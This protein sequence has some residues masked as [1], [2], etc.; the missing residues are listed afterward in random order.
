MEKEKLEKLLN[1]FVKD[2]VFLMQYSKADNVI[3]L[4]YDAKMTV[5][6][7]KKIAKTVKKIVQTGGVVEFSR[8]LD[9]DDLYVQAAAAQY[10]YPVAPEKC[11]KILKTYSESLIDDLD[12]LK[13]DDMIKGFERGDQFFMNLFAELYGKEM[14]KNKK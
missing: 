5:K 9:D 4:D 14:W 13:V 12:K 10:L 3:K 11:I 2:Q 1:E 6:L 7:G 8:L